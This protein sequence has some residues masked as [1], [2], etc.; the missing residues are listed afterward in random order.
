MPETLQKLYYDDGYRVIIISNQGGISLKKYDPKVPKSHQTKLS[1]FKE[2]V[3][4][5]L[6]Q[7]DI[8]ISVYA[9]TEKDIFRKPRTGMWDEVLEDHDIHLPSDLDLENSIF[10]GDAGGRTAAGGKP[11]D[12]SCSDRYISHKRSSSAIT[13]KMQKLCGQYWY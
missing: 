6:N 13:Y 3:S 2:K 8:P 7:L 12:F 9:S 10:V 1:S 11:K 5:V 4:A